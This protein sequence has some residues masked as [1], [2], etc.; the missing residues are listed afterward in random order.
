MAGSQQSNQI[1]IVTA[2]YDRMAEAI[3]HEA[4]AA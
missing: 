3:L 1:F 4:D 2:D